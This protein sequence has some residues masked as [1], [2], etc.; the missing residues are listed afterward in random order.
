MSQLDLSLIVP[1]R[2]NGADK[3]IEILKEINSTLSTTLSDKSYEIIS[4]DSASNDGSFE[5]VKN[6]NIPHVNIVRLDQKGKG[7]ALCRGFEQATGVYIGF[8]D[9]DGEINPNVLSNISNFIESGN[10]VLL[11]N[12]YLPKSSREG[13]TLYRKIY[14]RGY[15]LVI[16]TL[17][18]LKVKDSQTGFKVFRGNIIKK[19][20]PDLEENEF[21]I[22]IEILC[23]INC[24]K[25]KIQ[26]VPISIKKE[27][28]KH[29]NI[30]PIT[31]IY[32]FV[33][34]LKMLRKIS[35]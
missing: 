4:V 21:N 8:I 13:I 28:N 16:I 26:E 24:N 11:A 32:M 23:K 12:K 18:N 29:E 19:V 1:F 7:R 9:G 30:K 35:C 25:L 31:A 22:D 6:A 2:N 34:F 20:L 3:V 5:I 10:D 33:S 14:S 17:T 27:T 15:S